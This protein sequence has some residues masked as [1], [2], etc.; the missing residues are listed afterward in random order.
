MCA[1]WFDIDRFETMLIKIRNFKNHCR[2][3]SSFILL[4]LYFFCYIEIGTLYNEIEFHVIRL[5]ATSFHKWKSDKT[6]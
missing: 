3:L 6:M 1:L 5:A 2:V 4:E